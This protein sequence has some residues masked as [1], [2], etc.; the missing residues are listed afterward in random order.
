VNGPLLAWWSV[1]CGAAALNVVAWVLSFWFL[2]KK[3]RDRTREALVWLS[4]IYVLGCGFR[5]VFPMVDVPRICLH[6][7]WISRIAVGRTIATV[8]EL[9]FAV[10]WTLL[11]KEAGGPAARAGRLVVPLIVLAEAFSWGAV[12]TR[13]NLLHAV[14]NA[15]WTLTA[16]LALAGFGSLHGR[17]GVAGRRFLYAAAVCGGAY[18][19]FMAIVD[20]PMYLARW[21]QAGPLPPLGESART[22]LE[23]CLV[24]RDWLAWR[25][26]ALWLTLYFTAAVWISLALPHAPVLRHVR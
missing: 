14:E 26:D 21:M 2:K 9:A 22:L 10:Q 1:L 24:D 13:N 6:D 23:R 15:L 16:A 19:A 11:L 4:A 8:A 3:H 18:V 12:I 5:S 20:V 25:E 17:L 7:T